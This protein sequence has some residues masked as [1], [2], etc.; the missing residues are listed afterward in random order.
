[1]KIFKKLLKFL[2]I[3][4]ELVPVNSPLFDENTCNL[5]VLTKSP[6]ISYLTKRN[7]FE[8]NLS[9]DIIQ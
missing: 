9:L 4:F 1:M 6:K 2:L 7:L 8:I 5:Q 3:A